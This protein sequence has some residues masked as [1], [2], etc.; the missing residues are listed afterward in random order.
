MWTVKHT[1]TFPIFNLSTWIFKHTC[2][3]PIFNLSMWTVKHTGTFPIFNLST[4]IFKHTGT[5]PIFNLSMWTVKHTGNFPNFNLPTWIF[6]HTGTF[7]TINSQHGQTYLYISN[8]QP[9]VWIVK[10]ILAFL[11]LSTWTLTGTFLL[12]SQ[13]GWTVTPKKD[14]QIL[15]TK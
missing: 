12:T 5:F 13:H 6:K 4:W 9:L 11:Q 10:N 7:P 8:Y 15:A 3:F 14:I 2:T 1:G